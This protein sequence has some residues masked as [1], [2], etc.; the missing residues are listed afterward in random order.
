MYDLGYVLVK[1]FKFIFRI[2]LSDSALEK[3]EIKDIREGNLSLRRLIRAFKD[4]EISVL[5]GLNVKQ[6]REKDK[7]KKKK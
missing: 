2:K 7:E 6:R 5:W 1:V 3:K 4:V